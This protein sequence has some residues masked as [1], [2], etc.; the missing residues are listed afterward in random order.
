[1]AIPTL[2]P[3]STWYSQGG[4]TVKRNT[5]TEI[6]IVDSYTPS[7]TVTSSWDASAAKDGGVMC[8]VEGTKLT[9]AGNGSGKI[10]ANADSTNLFYNSK[11]DNFG[12]VV[13]ITGL[14][15][16]DTSN[17]TT[18]AKAF[19]RCASLTNLD[20][21]SWDVSNVK[22]MTATF[23]MCSSVENVNVAGWDTSSCEDMKGLFNGCSNLKTVDISHFD[24]RK[25]TSFC[26]MF[27]GAFSLETLD[28]SGWNPISCTDMS[29]MFNAVVDNP[30][31]VVSVGDISN[32]DVRKVETTMRMFRYCHGLETLNLDNWK[33]TN[34]TNMSFMFGHCVNLKT[35]GTS[36]WDT[37]ACTQ[38]ASMFTG[39]S[40]LKSLNTSNWDVSKVQ[41]FYHTF[42]DCYSLQNL[43]TTG[44]NPKSCTDMS[45]MFW[46]AHIA[47]S[48]DV[49][50]WDV[51]K[52]KNFD[53]M[54]AHSGIV[55]R[56][57]ENWRTTSA[58]NMNAMFHTIGNTTIDVSNF[59]TSNVQFFCQMFEWSTKLASIKGLENFNTSNGLGFDEMFNSCEN[60]R[61][62]NLSSFDTRKA[63][64]GVTASTNGHLTA[65]L[66]SMFSNMPRLK[67]I[68]LGENFSFNGDGTTTANAAVLPTPDS[69]YIREADGNWYDIDKNAFEPSAIPNKTAGTYY[70][71]LAL[72][73]AALNPLSFIKFMCSPKRPGLPK[74]LF[75]WK[76]A[77]K[78]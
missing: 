8:Y 74:N 39:C 71:S 43:N 59:D 40:K 66:K 11:T 57:V 25:V 7:G 14:D 20:V 75:G 45:F 35:L 23:Q 10:Y 6:H 37:S 32:W 29:D 38:M 24:V 2:A 76:L 33:L 46:G 3:N 44:W 50:N 53:H 47:D 77:Q 41:T 17:V 60:L 26:A 64:D 51:S 9:I 70:A 21:H 42:N 78:N 28:L 4:T 16:L 54:T 22:D 13:A 73:D 31:P 62:L 49:S 69:A 67:K 61:E 27:Q 58:T 36:N 52:V 68:T 72:V 15:I 65:T 5:I 55:L 19:T 18:L 63:K 34:C 48:L 12:S 56:G 1:M 30:C